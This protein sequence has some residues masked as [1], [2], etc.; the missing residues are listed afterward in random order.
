MLVI[1]LNAVGNTVKEQTFNG[2]ERKSIK[3]ERTINEITY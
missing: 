3:A 1:F 2:G